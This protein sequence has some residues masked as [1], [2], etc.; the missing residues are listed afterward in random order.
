MIKSNTQFVRSLSATVFVVTSL[1]IQSC[2]NNPEALGTLSEK[3]KHHTSSTGRT[4]ILMAPAEPQ[5]VSKFTAYFHRANASQP[6]GKKMVLCHIEGSW[7]EEVYHKLLSGMA[8]RTEVYK[9]DMLAAID[10]HKFDKKADRFVVVATKVNALSALNAAEQLKDE[11]NIAKIMLIGAPLLG[12][13]CFDD[14]K[15]HY[16]QP[17][18]PVRALVKGLIH[19]SN[20]PGST[21]V[22]DLTPGSAYLRDR[23]KFIESQTG[24]HDMEI[25]IADVC[26]KELCWTKHTDQNLKDTTLEERLTH[27]YVNNV[28]RTCLA[29]VIVEEHFKTCAAQLCTLYHQG[30]LPGVAEF[31][32]WWRFLEKTDKA[33]YYAFF[34]Y[35]NGGQDH[36]GYTTVSSQRGGNIA[37]KRVKRGSFVGYSGTIG[38]RYK[39]L[40]TL[41]KPITLFSQYEETLSNPSLHKAIF[42]FAAA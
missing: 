38:M 5:K 2:M 4:V 29:E 19:A 16:A 27:N 33:G 34:K 3:G 40:K 26:A 15:Q 12:C 24:E 14:N 42:D 11:V 10:K 36:D 35:L 13:E 41:Q 8:G 21:L 37:N 20:T 30:N 22:E 28:N 18:G 31:M 9:Q 1:C 39:E 32:D 25:Y 6:D 17:W 23:I 7:N